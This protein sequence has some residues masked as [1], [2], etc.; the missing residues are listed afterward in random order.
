[1]PSRGGTLTPITTLDSARGELDHVLPQR[2]SD[3]RHFLYVAES[4]RAEYV[5]GTLLAAS[6][7]GGKPTTVMN[8][9]GLACIYAAPNH[10]LVVRDADIEAVPFDPRSFRVDTTDGEAETAIASGEGSRLI[11]ASRTGTVVWLSENDDRRSSIELVGRDGKTKR[12]IGPPEIGLGH[13]YWAPR[14]SP[15]G[16]EVAAEHHLGQGGG[17]IYVFD[18]A[19][20]AARRETF[21]PTN[22]SGFVVWSPDGKRMAFNTTRQ[23][24]GNIF[25]KTVGAA[26]DHLFLGTA[27]SSWPS[28]WSRDGKYILF[29]RP[30]EKTQS[31]VWIVPA[32]GGAAKPI[33]AT[34]AN[35]MQAVFSPDGQWIAYASDEENGVYNVYVRPFPLTAEQWKVSESGGEAPRWRGDGKELFFLAPHEHDVAMMSAAIETGGSFRAAK[36]VELFRRPISIESG[37]LRSGVYYDVAADGQSFVTTIVEHGAT[38]GESVG[39]AAGALNVF[40]NGVGA[41]AGQR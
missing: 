31:D 33:L 10:L 11:A 7:D 32:G 35:E 22:H 38:G 25:M 19:T 12:M 30:S 2:L 27:N 3:G 18:I 20:G 39:A 37:I 24:G 21:D 5:G 40:V 4:Y 8:R 16:R 17:D 13:E 23:G 1:V 29:D 9:C 34:A 36:P 28:D 26:D 41:G 15:D 14:L 6:I